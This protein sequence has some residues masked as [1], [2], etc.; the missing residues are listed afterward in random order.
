MSLARWSRALAVAAVTVLAVPASASADDLPGSLD[1]VQLRGD[2][3]DAVLTAEGL[4]DGATIDPGSVTVEVSGESVPA[5]VATADDGTVLRRV[6]LLVDVSGSMRGAGIDAA[7]RAADSFL[8]DVPPDVR[9]GV[10][11]F[12]DS[13][14]VLAEPTTDRDAVRRVLADVQPSRETALYDAVPVALR[15]LGDGGAR[16]LLLLR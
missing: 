16:T 6:V 11:A 8:D 14:R 9:V 3:I 12:N 10:V 15:V 4:P 1:G 7:R 13:T 2:R 5:S